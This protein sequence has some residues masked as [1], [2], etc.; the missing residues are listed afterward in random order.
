MRMRMRIQG[1][2]SERYRDTL[3]WGIPDVPKHLR[4][5]LVMCDTTKIT[6]RQQTKPPR[7]R[8]RGRVRGS[9]QKLQHRGRALDRVR[10]SYINYRIEVES[11]QE[12]T[13]EK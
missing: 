2:R 4:S 7:G 8:L 5:Q 6:P 1:G 11:G 12:L 3:M 13:V 9:L 10:S